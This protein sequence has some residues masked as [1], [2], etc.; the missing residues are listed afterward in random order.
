MSA[1]S[2]PS[3]SSV[4]TQ[5]GKHKNVVLTNF[6][7]S[8][9]DSPQIFS[10]SNTNTVFICSLCLEPVPCKHAKL[11]IPAGSVISVSSYNAINCSKCAL[12]FF[13]WSDGDGLCCELFIEV[14]RVCLRGDLRL[15]GWYQL[16]RTES[17][18]SGGVVSL[19]YS[20][21]KTASHMLLSSTEGTLFLSH[22]F[23]FYQSC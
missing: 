5:T 18:E 16:G 7:G 22:Y 14:A 9:P 13:R 12:T 11:S 10:V 23:F 15:E 17:R 1:A 2:I 8:Y 20:V 6:N 21:F 19:R 4:K 3:S